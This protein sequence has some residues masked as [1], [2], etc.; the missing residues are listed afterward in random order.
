MNID[1]PF[2]LGII[3]GGFAK[4]AAL[5]ALHNSLNNAAGDGTT[6]AERFYSGKKRH[7]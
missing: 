4:G 3:L 6:Y 7:L 5:G 1:I 2:P